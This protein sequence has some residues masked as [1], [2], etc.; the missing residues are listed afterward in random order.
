MFENTQ[1]ELNTRG[2]V[3]CSLLT[4]NYAVSTAREMEEGEGERE[5]GETE[6]EREGHPT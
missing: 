2:P 6:R 1:L 5:G 3:F 4:T